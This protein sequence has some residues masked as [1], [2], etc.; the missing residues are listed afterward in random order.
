MTRPLSA[1]RTKSCTCTCHRMRFPHRHTSRCPAQKPAEASA[2]SR[3]L[4]RPA[5]RQAPARLLVTRGTD[6]RRAAR[7]VVGLLKHPSHTSSP[8]CHGASSLG[9][10]QPLPRPGGRSRDGV[11]VALRTWKPHALPRGESF[12]HRCCPHVH[13]SELTPAR[14]VFSLPQFRPHVWIQ[15]WRLAYSVIA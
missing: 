1:A 11:V 5:I 10:S 8:T 2:L 12:I 6:G 13:R 4:D 7:S 14:S 3:Q 9:P 15:V